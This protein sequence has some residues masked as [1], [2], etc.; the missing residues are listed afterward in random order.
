[1]RFSF[2]VLATALLISPVGFADDAL[3]LDLMGKPFNP[4]KEAVL[5]AVNMNAKYSEITQADRL[6]IEDLLLRISEALADGKNIGALDAQS[7][8]NIEL[9]QEAVNKLLLKAYRDSRLVC[10]KEA[11]LGSN[12]MKRVCKKAAA[13]NRDNANVRANGIKVNQ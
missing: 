6:S 13:R 12:M 5:N 1:M 3:Q 4:Q 2:I 9:N 10:T 8:Q 11:P 7:R